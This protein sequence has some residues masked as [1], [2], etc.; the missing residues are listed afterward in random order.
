M[1]LEELYNSLISEQSP[2]QKYTNLKGYGKYGE[3]IKNAMLLRMLNKGG[4][5]QVDYG[6]NLSR[7][8]GGED[9]P[10]SPNISGQIRT[11]QMILAA[12]PTLSPEEAMNLERVFLYPNKMK[13][14]NIPY[15]YLMGH[16]L[17]HLSDNAVK[18]NMNPRLI[19]EGIGNRGIFASPNTRSW[20]RTPSGRER[21]VSGYPLAEQPQERK[22]SL[23]GFEQM[24]LDELS[25]R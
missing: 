12:N 3:N 10:Q 16:E 8:L 20:E 24:F 1:N 22:A 6:E 21:F 13:E 17:S 7:R 9:Y 2:Y 14:F 23:K 5:K 15:S 4:S 25:R 11:W 19:A 18:L